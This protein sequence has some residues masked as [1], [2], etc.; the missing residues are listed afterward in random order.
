LRERRA[1]IPGLVTAL[2]Q[3]IAREEGLAT[4]SFSDEAHAIL[5]RQ[6]WPE[7]VR[8]LEA[9]VARVVLLFPGEEVFASEVR[10][11]AERMGLRLLPR[12]PSRRPTEG[13]LRAALRVTCCLSGATNKTRA[14]AYLGWD[15][16]T[17]VLRLREARIHPDRAPRLQE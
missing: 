4:P 10:L 17:L 12:I 7:N 5:W 14:A 9:L 3:R 15:P 11:A 2:A 8:G 13:D 1:A 16:D 6:P